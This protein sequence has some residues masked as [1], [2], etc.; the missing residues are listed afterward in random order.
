MKKKLRMGAMETVPVPIHVPMTVRKTDIIRTVHKMLMV[1][2]ERKLS[3]S[4][5]IFFVSHSAGW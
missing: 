4:E 5:V 1:T 2:T 3:P